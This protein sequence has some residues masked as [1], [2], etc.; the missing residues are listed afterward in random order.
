MNLNRRDLVLTGTG[1]AASLAVPGATLA[2]N[3][4][5]SEAPTPPHMSTDATGGVPNNEKKI[6]IVSLRDLE[7]E[8]QKVMAPFGF[9]YVSGGAGD[10]WT[11]RENL[12]AFNRWVINPDFMS[13]WPSSTSAPRQ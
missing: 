12:A 7:T 6:N 1:A 4:P 10:E 8:A 5:G 2:Q 3:G 13:A 11:M 9:A